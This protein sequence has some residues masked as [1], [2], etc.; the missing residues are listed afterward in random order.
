MEKQESLNLI[1]LEDD[2]IRLEQA[3]KLHKSEAEKMKQEFFDCGETVINGSALFDQMEFDPWL[4]NVDRNHDPNTVRED[5]AV[6]TTFLQ[7][8]NQMGKSSE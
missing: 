7:S 1:I 8:V 5:W 2:N 3:A 4:I 6:A